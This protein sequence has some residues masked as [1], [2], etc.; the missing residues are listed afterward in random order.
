MANR[1]FPHDCM[2]AGGRATQDAKAEW[3][4][5]K[6]DR[7]LESQVNPS[8]LKPFAVTVPLR[9]ADASQWDILNK[10]VFEKRREGASYHPL[11]GLAN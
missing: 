4:S 9:Q 7:L 10:K 2:D 6:S 8:F 3:G 1:A 5:P 11:T